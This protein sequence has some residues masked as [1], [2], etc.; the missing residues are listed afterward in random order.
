VVG[1]VK[2]LDERHKSAV[3][4]VRADL[5]NDTAFKSLSGDAS[6]LCKIC[7]AVWRTTVQTSERIRTVDIGLPKRFPDEAPI[8][9][10]HEWSDLYLM[11]PHVL[12]EGILCTIPTATALDSS[13]PVGLLRY[14]FDQAKEILAGTGSNDFREE[15]SSY[16]ARCSTKSAQEVLIIEAVEKLE[17]SF[18]VVFCVGFVCVASSLQKINSWA[19]N[20]LDSK[21]ELNKERLGVQINLS[22]PLLPQDYP[23]TI[24]DLVSL[25]EATDPS[26]AEII[27]N[28]L[29]TSTE[30][31]LA[32]LVQQEGE[33]KALGGIIFKGLYS[34]KLCDGYR[35]GK[36]PIDILRSR[37]A[38]LFNSTQIKRSKVI[39]VD[40]HWIHSRGGDGKDLSEKKVLLIGCGSLGGYVAHLLS[41]AGVGHLTV[42]DNDHLGWENLGRH[43][44]GASSVGLSK[45]LALVQKLK[46]ELPHL[47]IV[48]IPK[49]WRDIF[50]WDPQLFEKFDLVISTVAEWRCEKAL[51]TLTRKTQMAPLILGW[52]EPHAV[53]GHCL[54]ITKEGGCFECSSNEYGQFTNNVADFSGTTISREPGGCTHYQHYGPTALMPVASMIASV[55]VDSLLNTPKESALNT[56]ISNAEHF[57]LVG[58]SVKIEWVPQVEQGGYSRMFHKLWNK[59]ASCS[60]CTNL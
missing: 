11:N 7:S 57:K 24:A 59:S 13:N 26:T 22:E 55:A 33:G 44:L 3:E 5:E 38:H 6:P 30:N 27:K 8:A 20:R 58:A 18:P 23:K 47:D 34:S 25:A 37:T 56:W 10:V 45:A 40:H 4:A 49:D 35:P 9:C 36:I 43:I 48:G 46:S 54:V 15:F 16:W 12:E 41:R 42:T 50:E 21:S 17:K 60:L 53:A 51:N 39:R 14:V 2:L 1:L 32:L 52:L 29:L 19:S 28:H 31:A